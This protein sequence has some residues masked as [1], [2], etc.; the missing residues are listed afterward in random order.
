M[1]GIQR[2]LEICKKQVSFGEGPV[3][4]WGNSCAGSWSE[5][6]IKNAV[7]HPLEEGFNQPLE[8]VYV[9]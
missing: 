8:V 2:I 6:D 1:K 5:L 7:F 9:N 4:P 3:S